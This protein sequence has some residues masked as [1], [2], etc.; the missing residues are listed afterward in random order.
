MSPVFCQYCTEITF[1]SSFK[2]QRTTTAAPNQR[3][4]DMVQQFPALFFPQLFLETFQSHQI[5]YQIRPPS[6]SSSPILHPL[7]RAFNQML[8]SWQ[9]DRQPRMYHGCCW[10]WR[11]RIEGRAY[12]MKRYAVLLGNCWSAIIKRCRWNV[13]EGESRAFIYSNSQAATF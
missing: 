1:A 3:H 6:I 2:Y 9:S 8:I 12:L 10:W 4:S 7:T 11:R 5:K 13:M